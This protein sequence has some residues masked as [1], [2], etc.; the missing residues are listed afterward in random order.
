MSRPKPT[1]EDDAATEA[2]IARYGRSD[3]DIS[4]EEHA[5][6]VRT[7]IARLEQEAKRRREHRRRLKAAQRA[8]PGVNGG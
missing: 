4:D 5:R 7:L 8:A 2:R 6:N 1:P 3:A